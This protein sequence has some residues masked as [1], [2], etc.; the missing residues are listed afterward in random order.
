[1]VWPWRTRT[2]PAQE[3]QVASCR[4]TQGTWMTASVLAFTISTTWAPSHHFS[5]S[6]YSLP[7]DEVIKLDWDLLWALKF[8]D[9]LTPL[10]RKKYF[11]P[12]CMWIFVGFYSKDRKLH[13]GRTT[14]AMEDRCGKFFSWD[15]LGSQDVLR[16]DS[17]IYHLYSGWCNHHK[18]LPHAC[19]VMYLAKDPI[20]L[21]AVLE[22][23]LCFIH[24]FYQIKILLE[25]SALVIK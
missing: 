21:W 4:T 5:E 22:T 13:P 6:Q 14:E 10:V 19:E 23:L 11:F 24:T 20:T 7:K 3:A 17:R 15:S 9:S 8:H 16:Q 1:M 25:L 18:Q 12:F 2:S